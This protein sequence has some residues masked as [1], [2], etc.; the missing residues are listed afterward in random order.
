MLSF[1]SREMEDRPHTPNRHMGGPFN[2]DVHIIPQSD[3]ELEQH[4]EARLG[5]RI[6]G[7]LRTSEMSDSGHGGRIAEMYRT[8]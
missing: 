7:N 2:E 8:W 6:H 1:E 3:D 4:K 5:A